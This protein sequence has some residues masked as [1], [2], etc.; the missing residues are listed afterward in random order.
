MAKDPVYGMKVDEK[1]AKYKT[2]Q[3]RKT[4]HFCCSMCK[5]RFEQNPH[6]YVEM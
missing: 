3:M 5:E 6:K 2:V 1:T 4:Y